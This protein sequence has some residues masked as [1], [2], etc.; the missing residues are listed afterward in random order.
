MDARAYSA[1]AGHGEGRFCYPRDAARAKRRNS[2]G[3]SL[4]RRPR[5]RDKLRGAGRVARHWTSRAR[6]AEPR[7]AM[8][9][10]LTRTGTGLFRRASA[11][12]AGVAPGWERAAMSSAWLRWAPAPGV[13]AWVPS[14]ARDAFARDRRP[15]I[16]SAASHGKT[17]RDQGTR[18]PS[19]APLRG[20]GR[21]ATGGRA[22]A[23]PHGPARDQVRHDP[24][25]ER[26][27]RVRAPHRPVGRRLSGTCETHPR[28]QTPRSS[29]PTSQTRR[30]IPRAPPSI[31]HHR[32][33]SEPR[34]SITTPRIRL[35]CAHRRRVD[36][37]LGSS[38]APSHR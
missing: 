5:G 25:V 38:F 15:I 34:R 9:R 7:V 29:S 1:A 36:S 32:N 28:S 3:S 10:A 30:P 27:R 18:A 2:A 37:P 23:H 24:R 26:T 12:A 13:D 21:R 16:T 20:D 6:S 22:D 14:A 31:P 33:P 8:L 11:A 35:A 4:R 17:R 19:P